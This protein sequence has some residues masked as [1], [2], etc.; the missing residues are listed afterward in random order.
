M[1]V[2]GDRLRRLR[3]KRDLTLEELARKIG[4]HGGYVSDIENGKVSPPSPKVIRRIAKFFSQDEKSLVRTAW[5]DSAP[6][7]IQED[8]RRLFAQMDLDGSRPVPLV[9]VP[10][11]STLRSGPA[12]KLASDGRVL[13]EVDATLLLPASP[14]PVDAAAT[15]WDDSMKGPAGS[16]YSRGDVVLLSKEEKVPPNVAVYL[17]LS[18]RRTRRAMIRRAVPGAGGRLILE[19]W[20]RDGERLVTAPDDVDAV[21][22]VVG[23]I[24]TFGQ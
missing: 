6:A 13:P 21:Y 3:K 22:R 1:S 12:V 18:V 17:V 20:K 24:G 8:A 7:L 16:G 9:P 14:V 19:T 5:L 11:L 15:V 2:F 10:L 23:R 4:V